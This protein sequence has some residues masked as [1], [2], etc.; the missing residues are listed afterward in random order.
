[1]SEEIQK[2]GTLETKGRQ[3]FT[4][5]LTL[6]RAPERL[7]ECKLEKPTVSGN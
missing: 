5:S 1:M 7:K 4:K 2:D 6:S 3:S